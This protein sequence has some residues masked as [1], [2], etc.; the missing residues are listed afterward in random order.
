MFLYTPYLIKTNQTDLIGIKKNCNNLNLW[1]RFI[2]FMFSFVIE[3]VIQKKNEGKMQQFAI[4]FREAGEAGID[5]PEAMTLATVSGDGLPSARIVLLKN[6]DE[7]GF[8]FFTNYGSRKA[9]ELAENPHAALVFHWREMQRQVRIEG[10]VHKI[11]VQES[12]TYFNTRPVES[13]IG[14]W[15]S[16]QSEELENRSQLEAHIARLRE[17]LSSGRAEKTGFTTGSS[18]ISRKAIGTQSAFSRK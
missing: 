4:W 3:Q 15:A 2:I 1:V 11:S 14:A 16:R 18:I 12:R 6:F 10:V 17:K 9:R 13:Q 8:T 5:L 7:R